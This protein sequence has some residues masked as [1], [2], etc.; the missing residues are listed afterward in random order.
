MGIETFIIVHKG[1]IIVLVMYVWAP[2]KL[3]IFITRWKT[4]FLFTLKDRKVAFSS[5]LYFKLNSMFELALAWNLEIEDGSRVAKTGNH[6]MSNYNVIKP[7]RTHY[8]EKR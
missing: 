7:N 1:N 5:F 4:P 6:T 2:L 8:R 3:F